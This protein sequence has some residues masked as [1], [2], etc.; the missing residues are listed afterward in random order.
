MLFKLLVAFIVVPLIEL[1]LL[2]Q[3]AQWT[4]VGAT[5]ALV[6]ATGVLG[7]WLARREGV[8]AWRRFREALA[9]GRMP[10][11]EIQDGLMIVFAAALLLTPGLLT[12][13]LGFCLLVP[14]G[15]AWIRQHLMSGLIRPGSF[16]VSVSQ[17]F[18]EH[19]RRPFESQSAP[20]DSKTIDA[21]GYRRRA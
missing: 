14:A 1:Y 19:R 18:H 2:L 20:R 4:G 15:R 6:V 9:A 3:I 16:R 8:S 17:T 7:S 11:T 21:D 12:D 10:G 13:V 5:I